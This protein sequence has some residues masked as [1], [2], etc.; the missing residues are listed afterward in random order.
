ME[1]PFP[2]VLR[3]CSVCF[4]VG[5]WGS[6]PVFEHATLMCETCCCLDAQAHLLCVLFGFLQIMMVPVATCVF[7]NIFLYHLEKPGQLLLKTIKKGE[8]KSYNPRKPPPL[9]D[10]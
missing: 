4:R 2:W 5:P 10:F 3:E 1:A 6:V 8:H 7:T 9:A